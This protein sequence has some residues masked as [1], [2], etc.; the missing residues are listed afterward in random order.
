MTTQQENIVFGAPTLSSKPTTTDTKVNNFETD[1]LPLSEYLKV[2]ETRQD[3][4][5]AYPL[6]DLISWSDV[7]DSTLD[8]WAVKVST[9]IN[10]AVK[11]TC[12]K[13]LQLQFSEIMYQFSYLDKTVRGIWDRVYLG[14]LSEDQQEATHASGRTDDGYFL[15]AKHSLTLIEQLVDKL[16]MG[17][18]I[19][20]EVG[21]SVLCDSNNPILDL[22]NK[23]AITVRRVQK[24]TDTLKNIIGDDNSHGILGNSLQNAINL[25]KGYL[26]RDTLSDMRLQLSSIKKYSNLHC[27]AT[28][29]NLER[30]TIC[31]ISK[32]TIIDFYSSYPVD[33][34][35]YLVEM[36]LED[37]AS[38]WPSLNNS[39]PRVYLLAGPSSNDNGNG[40]LFNIHPHVASQEHHDA[41]GTLCMGAEGWDAVA[42]VGMSETQFNIMAIAD[43]VFGILATYYPS[44]AYCK[45]KEF[46]RLSP[47]H[48][49]N[50]INEAEKCEDCEDE[51]SDEG[52]EVT[53]AA[54]GIE[55][56]TE[57]DN[58]MYYEGDYF[59]SDEITWS[60][61]QN[62]YIDNESA[63][64]P[65]NA[66]GYVPRNHTLEA[67]PESSCYQGCIL[68]QEDF[69]P[70]LTNSGR[71]YACVSDDL[72]DSSDTYGLWESF[73][74]KV[75]PHTFLPVPLY[76]YDLMAVFNY[77][78]YLENERLITEAST[79][80]DIP[81]TQLNI[82]E[83]GKFEIVYKAEQVSSVLTTMSTFHGD[84]GRSL[85]HEA[86]CLLDTAEEN[87]TF[88]AFSVKDNKNEYIS[89]M[90]IS[91][92]IFGPQLINE[93]RLEFARPRMA[94]LNTVNV[95]RSQ[96][97]LTRR[98]VFVVANKVSLITANFCN[99]QNEQQTVLF[100]FPKIH[101]ELP[102]FKEMLEAATP[103]NDVNI[104]SPNLT[105][106]E[107]IDE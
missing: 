18:T 50:Y 12:I 9:T 77:P 58:C 62:T 7:K 51:D 89:K 73:N 99:P 94:R 27:C 69:F 31:F 96:E 71:I 6:Q 100:A 57:D 75:D 65:E 103:F 56:N 22:N 53:C 3:Y 85:Q 97:S 41:P 48:I 28:A 23:M 80:A 54:T 63:V 61:R 64:E 11:N 84:I 82:L 20:E 95:A 17:V 60:D 107:E 1:N 35:V 92:D 4:T 93:A 2:I 98:C 26:S 15:T 13:D 66:S 42:A 104:L 102:G 36:S 10:N 106:K 55:M 30:K 38:S 78:E 19:S 16:T 59:N 70:V 90:C 101:A 49:I 39:V 40:Q 52:C 37:M 74:E 86:L 45:L 44:D 5:D 46:T 105:P 79:A 68:M 14:I 29:C 87:C 83:S 88:I 21:D 47:S 81:E 8:K 33:L 91:A 67:A 25:K 34:G 43:I 72:T 32:P 76:I 24:T